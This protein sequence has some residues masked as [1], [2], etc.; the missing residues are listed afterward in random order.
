[1]NKIKI[2]IVVAMLAIFLLGCAT[3]NTPSA[4]VKTIEKVEIG[5]KKHL[6][7]LPLFVGLEK[8]F[9]AEQDLEVVVVPF[10]S[11]NQMMTAIA[12]GEIDASIG[13]SNLEAVLS[14]E[15]KSPGSLKVFSTQRITKD[16]RMSCVLVKKGSEVTTISALKNKKVATLPGSFAPLW[17]TATL[18]KEGINPSDVEIQGI[19]LKLHLSALE[20]GQID[21]LFTAEPLCAFGVNKG[22]ATILYDEPIKNLMSTFSASVVGTQTIA[23][24]AKKADKIVKATDKAIRYLESHPQEAVDILAKYASYEK[25]LLN[26]IKIPTY[27]TSS[28]VTG[29]ELQ[30]VADTLYE[31]GIIKKRI[32]TEGL[33]YS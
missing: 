28:E 15:E 13:G 7:Y 31:E 24:D 29:D 17:I 22:I 30:E 20:S 26:G 27:A 18:E 1:M 3:Q 25:N 14:L 11:T 23:D 19:D 8:G 16:S 12:T 2:G 5:Y 10:D 9:F 33:L 32:K 6:A 4:D 21:A